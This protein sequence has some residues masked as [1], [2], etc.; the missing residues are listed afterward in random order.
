MTQQTQQD[1]A[2]KLEKYGLAGGPLPAE[3]LFVK[4]LDSSHFRGKQS[5][6]IMV[7]HE[8]TATGANIYGA[9][10]GARYNPERYQSPFSPEKPGKWLGK[11]YREATKEDWEQLEALGMVTRVKPKSK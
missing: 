11:G 8:G 5:W 10:F 4:E 2:T 9:K 6:A 1:Q 3:Q 7:V